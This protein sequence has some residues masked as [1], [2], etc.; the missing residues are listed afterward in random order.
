MDRKFVVLYRY[1]NLSKNDYAYRNVILQ[2]ENYDALYKKLKEKFIKK[3]D[4][5]TVTEIT[6]GIT[7]DRHEFNQLC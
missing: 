7:E 5:E 2:A 1:F 3:S 6:E 4:V